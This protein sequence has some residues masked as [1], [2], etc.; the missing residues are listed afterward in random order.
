MVGVYKTVRVIVV[1]TDDLLWTHLYI[2]NLSLTVTEHHI[3][4]RT[5]S[6][7]REQ[8][9]TLLNGTLF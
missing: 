6:V 3:T 1:K 9:Y 5:G 7:M 8:V 2:G 4:R